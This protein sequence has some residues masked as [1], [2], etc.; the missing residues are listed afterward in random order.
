MK[1]FIDK[2]GDID[3]I[4]LGLA[5]FALIVVLV[6]VDAAASPLYNV[7]SKELR[8]KA[9]LKEAEWNRQITVE[10]AQANLE[11]EKLNAKAEVARA[12]D[13]AEANEIIGNSLRDNEEY[14]W[15]LCF[16]LSLV[17]VVGYLLLNKILAK[18]T[19]EEEIL[20]ELPELEVEYSSA[21]PESSEL[22]PTQL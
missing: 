3:W 18:N 9:A 21:H 7:W 14:L 8:G 4:K 2:N 19:G 10:E 11:A 22:V 17:A 6:I 1:I 5:I 16:I 20:A 13:V 12:V 15:Y